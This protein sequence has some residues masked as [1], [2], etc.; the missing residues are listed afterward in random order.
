MNIQKFFDLAAAKGITQSQVM[1]SN[2]KSTKISL[3]R[4]E[5]DTYKLSES[6][7]MVA[8]GI[9]NGKLG[10][11]ATE[12]VGDEAFDFLIEQIILTATYSEKPCEVGL[13]EGAEKY[14]RP[15]TINKELALVP[16]EKKIAELRQLEEDILAYD[17]RIVEADNVTYT[18]AESHG[19]Y[20]NSHGI[21]LKTSSNSFYFLGGAVAK[22]GEETK[23]FYDIYLGED[24]SKFD[25]QALV[26]SICEK[27]LSKFGGKPCA[28]KK[29]PTV[30][31]RDIVGDL[32]AY[33]LDNT[34]A[35]K[36]Q[37][38]TSALE[39]KIGQKIASSKLT[40]EQKPLEK[41]FYYSTFDDELVPCKN[42]VIVKN[43]VL[44]TYLYNRETAAKDGVETTANGVWGGSKFSTTCGPLYIKPGKKSFDEMIAP[45]KEGVYITEIAG[46]G[47][48]MNSTSGDF[49]CQAEGYMIEDGK[50]TTPLNLITISGNLFK[51]LNDIKEFDSNAGM[52]PNGS[53]ISVGDCYIKS[54]NIGGE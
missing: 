27:A 14:K 26:K 25:R 8:I 23:T 10:S 29:Y 50:V 37:K 12:L 43:G 51:L 19:E 40:I 24:Y 48:G 28:S 17:P 1:V 34:I 16:L 20:F 41:G 36:V 47:T 13:Y 11:G 7:S 49:S 35:E 45:I 9:Y 21:H 46:L 30:L 39:G 54:L 53:A 6:R 3:F 32:I 38:K 15:K 4:R 5:I 44:Q 33:F 22:E 31:H 18:E 42:F 52:L 2:S